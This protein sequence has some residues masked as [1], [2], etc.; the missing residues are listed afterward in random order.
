MF[1]RLGLRMITLSVSGRDPGW[2]GHDVVVG[3]GGLN[4][5]G[6]RL[7]QEM[8]SCGILIDLAHTNENSAL[9]IIENSSV[10]VVDTHSNPRALEENTRN[11]PDEVMKK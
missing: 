9:D 2:D 4:K 10:P 8:N 5:L 7:I 11:T 6:L 3:S 1:A